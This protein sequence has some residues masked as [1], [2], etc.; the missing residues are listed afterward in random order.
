MSMPHVLI[1]DD[2]ELARINLRHTLARLR[3]WQVSGMAAS[4][5][6]AR[7]LM[8]QHPPDLV[9]L[10]IQM[11]HEHGLAFASELASQAQPPL[12][13][14]VTAH[15]EHALAAF[16]VH[17]LDYLL[18]P[19]SD[20]RLAQA[21]GRV[22]EQ[23]HQRQQALQADSLADYVRERQAVQHQSTLPPLKQL[24]VRSVGLL[25]RVAVQDLVHL[26]AAANYVELTLRDGRRLLHRAT[27]SALEERLPAGEFLRVHR[28]VLVRPE[29]IA[30]L[31]VEGGGIYS[32]RLQD[33]GS[34]PVSARHV[35]AVRALF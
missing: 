25:E 28:S 13:V 6:E 2:E 14:F 31:V 12:V 11:P 21:L 20:E 33:G 23:L 35:A 4:V 24:V 19:V 17:A 9:L 1:V 32:L 29:C 27:L 8:Q 10:D 18:K 7:T 15:D 16:E 3:N 22:E 34:L 5:A 26:S 30:S